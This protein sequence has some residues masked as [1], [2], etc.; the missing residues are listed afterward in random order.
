MLRDEAESTILPQIRTCPAEW[1]RSCSNVSHLIDPDC[2]GDRKRFY[3]EGDIS[4]RQ[5]FVLVASV[6]AMALAGCNGTAETNSGKAASQNID[7]NQRAR[8]ALQQMQSTDSH[9]RDVINNSYAYAILPD[10][11]RADLGIGGAGGQGIVYRNG[12]RIGTVK[13]N[14]LSIGAQAG[15]ANYSELIVFKDDQ[16]FQ[17]L[18]NGKLEFGAEANATIIK[19]G[20]NAN[21]QFQN[22]VAAY[23]LPQGGLDVGASLNGQKLTFRSDQNNNMQ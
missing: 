7:M 18:E 11:G 14:P 12:Q 22:G 9:L 17:R 13:L 20:A 8:T 21:D 4:M 19:A 1:N 5:T 2:V 6:I 10:V 3:S 16:A 23:I 15:G